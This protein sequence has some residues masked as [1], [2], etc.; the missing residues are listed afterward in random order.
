[1][2]VHMHKTCVGVCWNEQLR[3]VAGIV[4]MQIESV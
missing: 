4:K 3:A 2:Y 1:M